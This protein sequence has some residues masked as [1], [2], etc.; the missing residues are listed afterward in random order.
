MEVNLGDDRGTTA[1]EDEVPPNLTGDETD[2]LREALVDEIEQ[3]IEGI[4]VGIYERYERH[5]IDNLSDDDWFNEVL[6]NLA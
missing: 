4:R 1:D 6:N 5:R 2:R 3:E